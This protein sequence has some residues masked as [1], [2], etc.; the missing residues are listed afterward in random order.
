MSAEV[1]PK[2]NRKALPPEIGLEL[3]RVDRQVGLSRRFLVV[4]VVVVA[5]A[6]VGVGS[7]VSHFVRVGITEGV[8]NTAAASVDSVVSHLIDG[9]AAHETL[10]DADRA[11]LDTFFEISAD[12]QATRLIQVQIRRAD[13]TMLYDTPGVL[14]DSEQPAALERARAGIV[15]SDIVDLT[16]APAEPFGAHSLPVLRIVTPLHRSPTREVFAIATLYYGARSIVATE[17]STQVAVWIIVLATGLAVIAALYLFVV[18]TSRTIDLQAAR[19]KA[20]LAESRALSD[21]VRSLHRA[22]ELLRTDSIAA[23]EQLLDRVGSDIHD[24]PLQLLTLVILQLNGKLKANRDLA[25]TMAL[26][27]D[28]MTELRNISAGL[29]LPELAGLT[30]SKTIEAAIAKHEGATGTTV[31]RSLGDLDIVVDGAIQTCI[32]RVVQEALSNAFRH[33]GGAG[34]TVTASQNGGTIVLD[35]V[36]SRRAVR[37]PRPVRSLRSELRPRLG[38]R[39]MQVRVE[40]VGGG[41]TFEMSDERVVVHVR[42]PLRR[43]AS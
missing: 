40:A 31:A 24:G 20:D 30:L 36:N 10:S 11:E 33:A 17:T 39:G 14:L 28:A 35:V 1:T 22:S 38:V 7:L 19:L 5:L 4:S 21:E 29:V 2:G 6:M 26:T 9:L 27:S 18:A 16:L 32:Y 15:S 43:Q 8:A 34:Q 3:A 42:I 13:G 25:Q 23:N 37:A 41:L 12:A